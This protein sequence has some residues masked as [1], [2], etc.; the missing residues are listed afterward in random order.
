[1]TE[2]LS[3]IVTFYGPDG[4]GK[5]SVVEAL[6]GKAAQTNVPATVLGG[7]SYRQW[8][9]PRVARETLGDS[10][11]LDGVIDSEAKATKLYEDIAIACYGLAYHLREGG[12]EVLID[13][14]PYMKRM[15]WGSIGPDANDNS[16]YIATFN[17]RF[18]NSV[19][20][21]ARPDVIVGV[22][23]DDAHLSPN[24]L[25]ARLKH[26]GNNTFNDPETIVE[27]HSLLVAVKN[28][29]LEVRAGAMCGTSV[30]SGINKR[31]FGATVLDIKNPDRPS[32]DLRTRQL[33]VIAGELSQ[34]L[35]PREI[36]RS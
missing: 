21:G 27:M 6:A 13:S 25:L 16:S 14:D 5:S 31:I 10:S 30:Y 9:T 12:M 28:V 32:N 23:M 4:C 26:R 1:M 36:P 20:S 11:I 33:D 15:I 24:R 34:F 7:S 22:N 29:W 35:W 3:G 18:N 8:L 2:R 19:P 17:D